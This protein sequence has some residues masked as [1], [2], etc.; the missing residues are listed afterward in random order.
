[1]PSLMAAVAAGD[2]GGCEKDRDRVKRERQIERE[3]ETE[4]ETESRG[5]D[6]DRHRVLREPARCSGGQRGEHT[7]RHHTQ[8]HGRSARRRE[9]V[10]EE[11]GCGQEASNASTVL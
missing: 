6:G 11:T 2:A 5:R 1:M 7:G 4:T 8:P 10:D 3:T 9:M